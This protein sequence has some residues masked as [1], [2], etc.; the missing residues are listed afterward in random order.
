MKPS[1]L[2]KIAAQCSEMYSEALKS[3]CKDSVK[4]MWD[5][6]CFLIF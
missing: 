4:G 5:K 3:M 2:L 6:V 1:S